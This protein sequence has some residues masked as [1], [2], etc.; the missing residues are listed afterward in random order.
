MIDIKVKNI[1]VELRT[2]SQW[3]RWR[4]WN[5]NG[6]STKIPVSAVREGTAP[7]N[8]P[9]TWSSFNVAV[10]EDSEKEY[11]GIGF[12]L[13]E[14][15][16]FA[17]IDLDDVRNPITGEIDEGSL[18][19]IKKLDS[20]T[21]VSPSGKGVHIWVNGKVPDGR[22]RKG[23]FEVYDSD[24]Y[25]TVTGDHFEG[26]PL[27]INDR[28]KELED[29]YDTI[30]SKE[31]QDST[32]RL[33]LRDLIDIPDADVIERAKSAKNGE[34]FNKLWQGVWEGDYPSQ[35]EATAALLCILAFWCGPEE[36]QIDRLFRESKLNRD[37]W[38]QPVG[39]STWELSK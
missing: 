26:T 28:Q 7:V 6:K 2:I 34:K 14:S 4:Y 19:I 13:T 24:R 17:V 5:R 31:T 12:V 10:L 36:A 35:S 27:K 32:K 8:E 15:E 1:P 25:M 38:D 33:S 9:E 20:Y 21:E 11:D 16:S 37:K 23:N 22:R 30:F 3:V 39:G 18:E 29:V